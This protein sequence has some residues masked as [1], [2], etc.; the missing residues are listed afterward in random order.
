MIAG[1]DGLIVVGDFNAS[2]YTP[3]YRGFVEAAGLATFRPFP[4]SYPA[5]PAE[6]G[7]PID[8]VL[9]RGARVTQLQA[10]P[11]IGSDHRPATATVILRAEAP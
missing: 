11:T 8:H 7:I 9:A 1:L 10:L 3:A 6:F 2:P 5:G 4:A